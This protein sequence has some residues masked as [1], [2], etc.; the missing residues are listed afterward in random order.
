M[1][2]GRGGSSPLIDMDMIRMVIT[3]LVILA[4]LGLFIL[5]IFP[6]ILSIKT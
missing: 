3:A 5:V 1:S 6:A 2:N 4:I